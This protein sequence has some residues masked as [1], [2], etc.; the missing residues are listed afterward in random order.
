MGVGRL[1]R[2]PPMIE[3]SKEMERPMAYPF[4][5]DKGGVMVGIISIERDGEWKPFSLREYVPP[6]PELVIELLR[7]LADSIERTIKT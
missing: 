5:T 3:R 4:A 1:I 7:S 2:I 6:P